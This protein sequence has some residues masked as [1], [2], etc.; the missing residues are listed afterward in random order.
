MEVVRVDDIVDENVTYVKMD[1]EGAELDSLYGMEKIIKRDK[2]TLAICV[3][4]NNEDIIEIPEYISSIAP[5][6]KMYLR[7]HNW[8]AAETVLYCVPTEK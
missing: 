3:Y 1:I 4:H 6:Y 8:S 7:H 2:P 5:T